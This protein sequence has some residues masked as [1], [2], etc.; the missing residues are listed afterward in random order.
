MRHPTSHTSAGDTMTNTTISAELI[1]NMVKEFEF[2]MQPKVVYAISEF[3]TIKDKLV[4]IDT[5]KTALHYSQLK[6]LVIVHPDDE[7]KLLNECQR[8]KISAMTLRQW[9][10]IER[11]A[12]LRGKP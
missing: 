3:L 10:E 1:Q 11:E 9:D 2:W 12:F 5:E 8:H 7:Q 4:V 6:Q